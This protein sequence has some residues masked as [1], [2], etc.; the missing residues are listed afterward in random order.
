MRDTRRTLGEGSGKLI[1]FGEH[2]VVYG[3]PA[4]VASLGAGVTATAHFSKQAMLRLTDGHSGEEIDV[5]EQ[6]DEGPLAEAFDAILDALD[7]GAPVEVGATVHIPVGSGLGSSAA[8]GVAVSRALATIADTPATGIEAAVEASERVFHGEP[9]GID[10]TAA[11]R[12]GVFEFR[13]T[14]GTPD[15]RPLVAPPLRLL[16]CLAEDGS[17]T[18]QM[19]A[20]VRAFHDAY[21]EIADHI[22]TAIGKVA[23]RGADAL[24]D[25]DRAALGEAMRINH[26]LLVSLGVSTPAIERACAIAYEAGAAGAKL[27]GAG[28][29]G[30]VF[31]VAATESADDVLEAW[32]DA[33]LRTHSF[34]I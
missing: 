4:V 20:R 32:A 23:E 29:G 15:V 5:V 1:L 21:P 10:Q 3:K 34:D 16:I 18:A 25:G 11:L 19:V 27:T 6:G 31:A 14:D 12:G 9:S 33:G 17:P 2:A 7:I 13:R 22:D 24:V 30:C 26:G 8:L 28:G